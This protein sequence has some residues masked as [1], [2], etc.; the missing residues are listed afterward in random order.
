M[1]ESVLI[2][3]LLL[4]SILTSLAQENDSTFQETFISPVKHKVRLTGSFGELRKNHFHTGIDIK[5]YN[6]AGDSL[7]AVM[8]GYISRVRM[9]SGSYGK[10]VYITHPNG[11]TSVYAHLDEYEDHIKNKIQSKQRSLETFEIDYYLPPETLPVSQGDYIGMLGNTGRSTGPHLHFEI[12][13]TKSELAINPQ[14]YDF[15]VKDNKAPELEKFII[16]DLDSNFQILDKTILGPSTKKHKA[17]TNLIGIGFKGYD[18]MD[19]LPNKNGIADIKVYEDNRL[20][21]Y[22]SYDTISFY[23]MKYINA[24]IDYEEKV[25]NNSWYYMCYKLPE[26]R[27]RNIRKAVNDGLIE[28]N[29]IKDIKIVLKD[30]S[31]NRNIYD[32]KITPPENNVIRKKEKDIGLNPKIH[33]TL[34][35]QNARI[36]LKPGTLYKRDQIAMNYNPT[37]KDL[38]ISSQST[39]CQKYFNVEIKGVNNS[40]MCLYQK[41][42]SGKNY[43]L[44][45]TVVQDTFYCQ[46]NRFGEFFLKPDL[47]APTIKF[48]NKTDD[49]LKFWIKDDTNVTGKAME[50]NIRCTVD[51]QWI[52]YYYKS[53]NHLMEINLSDLNGTELVIEARDLKNN[54]KILKY[55]L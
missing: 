39:P 48:A 38:K 27:S 8:S 53:M 12:R 37:T 45:G 25:K 43:N 41:D 23:E 5:K 22:A 18:Q 14:L 19:G 32:L 51:G 4:I 33:H 3:C 42:I 36:N 24:N 54:R 29:S 1:R 50:V 17:K 16:H 20:I 11:T 46:I 2:V 10:S 47:K 26:N 6:P 28:I 30:L 7:F 55:K 40:K 21:Y 49:K 13:N 15:G 35:S 52:P 44:G 34:T 31:G 9:Q